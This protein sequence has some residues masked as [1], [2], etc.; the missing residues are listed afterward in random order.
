M[1]AMSG[2]DTIEHGMASEPLWNPEQ[3]AEYLGIPVET[4]RSWKRTGYGPRPGKVGRHVR[5]DPVEVR[6]WFAKQLTQR[7]D[8]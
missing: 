3:V 7:T 6:A 1:I 2:P 5:Y 8:S 4:L